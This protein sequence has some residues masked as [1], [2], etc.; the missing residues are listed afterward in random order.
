MNSAR[1]WKVVL[2]ALLVFSGHAFAQKTVSDT[3][4]KADSL[5]FSARELLNRG[6]ASQAA[7]QF[8]LVWQ[9]YPSSTYAA[10]ARYWQAWAIVRTDQGL[11]SLKRALNLL[12]E[13]TRLFPKSA[14]AA[15]AL[16]LA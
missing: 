13:Q 2:T 12:D 9:N 10:E 7:T 15:D 11:P 3:G 14:V 5:Y 4:H 1:A 16:D 6:Q 8:A